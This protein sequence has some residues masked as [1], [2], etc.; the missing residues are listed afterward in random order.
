MAFDSPAYCTDSSNMDAELFRRSIGTLLSSAGGIVTPGDLAVTQQG[1]PNMS[2]QVGVGQAWIPGSTTTT[3]GPYYSRNGASVTQAINAANAANPRIDIIC[4]QVV[5]KAYAGAATTCAVGYV[6]GTPTSGATLSNLLGVGALP[7]SSLLLAYVL[8]PANASSIV[9][10]DIANVAPVLSV[11]GSRVLAAPSGTLTLPAPSPGALVTIQAA[12]S[13]TGASPATIAY[14]S[15]G[16]KI[17]GVGLSSSG[18][19]SFPLGT[20]FASV[21]LEG[22]AAGTNWL[23][24]GGQHDSGWVAVTL[25]GGVSNAG[26]TAS[27]RLQGDVVRLKGLLSGTSITAWGTIPTALRPTQTVQFNNYLAGN[28]FEI[29][30]STGN[31]QTASAANQWGLD[32]M[33]YTIS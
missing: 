26:Y 9:T 20:P 33:T 23:I 11:A 16:G 8:V 15:G 30:A 10:A 22:D 13:V 4:A 17:F 12:S 28:G 1:S 32:G 6:A 18:V 29:V 19:A 27:A 14:G 5:D 2:V 31:M 21:T 3:Q 25:G 7:A 24:V